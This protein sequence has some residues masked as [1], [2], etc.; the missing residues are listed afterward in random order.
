MT[1]SISR[2][3]RATLALTVL[4]TVA[5]LI[6]LRSDLTQIGVSE[7]L[8]IPRGY[9]D[10]WED[11]VLHAR[12]SLKHGKPL[13]FV[14]FGLTDSA[15]LDHLQQLHGLPVIPYG[16]VIGDGFAFWSGYNFVVKTHQSTSETHALLGH[17]QLD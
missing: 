4:L 16:C 8:S 9:V 7:R 13:H 5:G 17:K 11:G 10:T 1:A 15:S 14:A 12:A 2:T 6:S 3:L